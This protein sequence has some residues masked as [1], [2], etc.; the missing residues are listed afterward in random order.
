LEFHI[1]SIVASLKAAEQTQSVYFSSRKWW[2]GSVCSPV[3]SNIYM[4]YMLVWWFKEIV[5]PTL[6]GYSGL[7]VYADDFV[8]C[9]QCKE[10]AERFYE[11]LKHRMEYFG[12]HLEESKSRLIE[13]GRYAEIN[14]SGVVKRSQKHSLFLALLIIVLTADMVISE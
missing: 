1:S 11:R 13:F 7:V 8:V 4:H 6:K 3:I 2:Q 10:D 14:R 5:Q 12:L 9:F